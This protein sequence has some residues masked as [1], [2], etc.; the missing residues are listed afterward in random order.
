M[1]GEVTFNFFFFG[2]ENKNTGVPWIEPKSLKR[3]WLILEVLAESQGFG[4]RQ[5]VQK[6][7]A[8]AHQGSRNPGQVTVLISE[9]GSSRSQRCSEDHT[10]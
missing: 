7:A 6:A 5:P 2:Q 9:W 3:G 8:G 1:R 4:L 10:R